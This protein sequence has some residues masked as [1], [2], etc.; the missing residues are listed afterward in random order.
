MKPL[1][2]TY[3]LPPISD[4]AKGL[5]LPKAIQDANFS[6]D[7][8]IRDF[9]DGFVE[10]F[11]KP[12]EWLGELFGITDSNKEKTPE[13]KPQTGELP[14]VS[15]ETTSDTRRTTDTRE[16]G[17][18]ECAD[19]AKD[20]FTPQVLQEWGMMSAEA[21]FE[22]LA[23]YSKRVAEVLGVYVNVT[24]QEGLINEGC[25]GYNDGLGNVVLDASFVTDPA[26]V[27]EAINTIAHEIRHQFQRDVCNNPGKYDI[28]P[29]TVAE[30]TAGFQNYTQQRQTAEDP[31]GYFFNP[32]EIDARYFGE[33]V[34][35][36]LTRSFIGD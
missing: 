31:W 22:K 12:F 36:E 9:I 19:A 29:L 2:E 27:L 4:A 28:D 3:E 7:D 21:R 23:E 24:F 6:I 20:I 5:E 10:G 34:V 17:V 26:Q 14:P 25:W 32:V 30:W 8:Y 33:S 16:Y 11:M 1:G 18:Q 15:A 13:V 35:R